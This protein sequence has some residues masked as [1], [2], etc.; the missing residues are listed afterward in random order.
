MRRSKHGTTVRFSGRY[1]E[2]V[3]L[4]TLMPCMLNKGRA[5]IAVKLGE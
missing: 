3:T 1:S 2:G 4:H 5:A